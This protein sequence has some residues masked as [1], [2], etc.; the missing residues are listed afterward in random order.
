MA[1]LLKGKNAVITGAARGIGKAIAERYLSEGASLYLIDIHEENLRRTQGE[2]AVLAGDKKVGIGLAD[3]SKSA[4]V[5]R[6]VDGAYGLLGSIDIVVSNAGVAFE[7][8]FLQIEGDELNKVIDVNLKGMF[9]VCQEFARRMVSDARIR[10]SG[11]RIITMGSKNGLVGEPG[12]SHYD[13][14]KG[15]VIA[16]TRTIAAELAP[17]NITVNCVCP[18]YLVTPMSQEIDDPQFA[19]SIAHHLI[20]SRRTGTVED[21]TGAFVFLATD[22]ARWMVGQTLVVDGGQT[23]AS[24]NLPLWY[25]RYP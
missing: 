5:A 18:G 11:G 16:L 21:V 6:C 13:A 14:S 17:H 3:I 12:Y 22:D 19:R 15:G 4:D 2:L 10:K 25:E 1:D 23:S 8:P 7:T 20:P 9:L 24:G